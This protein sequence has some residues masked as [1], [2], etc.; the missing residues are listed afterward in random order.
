MRNIEEMERSLRK[1]KEYIKKLMKE[2]GYDFVGYDVLDSKS[3]GDLLEQYGKDYES[4]TYQ[5]KSFYKYKSENG[6]D[7]YVYEQY[8]GRDVDAYYNRIVVL[9]SLP[10]VN[11]T[12]IFDDYDECYETAFKMYP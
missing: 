7:L 6:Y 3:Y 2:K 8:A 12:R 9:K 5:G 11:I 4:I 1:R 10:K